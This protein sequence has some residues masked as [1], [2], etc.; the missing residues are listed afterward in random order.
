ML[1]LASGTAAPLLALDPPVITA[2]YD[3]AR[4]IEQDDEEERL[5]DYIRHTV[6]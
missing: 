4:G 5:P 3:T 1:L 6:G 2:I